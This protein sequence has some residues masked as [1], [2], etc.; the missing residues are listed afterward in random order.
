MLG[1]NAPDVLQVGESLQVSEAGTVMLRE[2]QPFL[3]ILQD[4]TS[5]TIDLE[6]Q[7]YRRYIHIR[8]KN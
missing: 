7:D 4:S 1:Y 5:N 2:Q 8:V 6:Q 3:E